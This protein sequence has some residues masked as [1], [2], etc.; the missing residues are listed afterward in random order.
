MYDK[1][2]GDKK[3]EGTGNKRI[4]ILAA[5][6]LDVIEKWCDLILCTFLSEVSEPII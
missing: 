5:N 4:F 6:S 1:R 3:K 2:S